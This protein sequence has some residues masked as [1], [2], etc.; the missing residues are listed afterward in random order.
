MIWN[1]ARS[2][3]A[4]QVA[5]V[6]LVALVIGGEIYQV[7][8]MEKKIDIAT[9]RMEVAVDAIVDKMDKTRGLTTCALE[10]PPFSFHY[11]KNGIELKRPGWKIV[12]TTGGEDEASTFRPSLFLF[13]YT[14][15][16]GYRMGARVFE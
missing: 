10:D 13:F 12:E 14:D 1:F 6:T 16:T 3:R 15:E 4:L 9:H 2:R 11:L 7:R 5:V 8:M